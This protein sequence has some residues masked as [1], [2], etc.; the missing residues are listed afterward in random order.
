MVKKRKIKSMYLVQIVCE[1]CGEPMNCTYTL[2][3]YPPQYCYECANCGTTLRT[4]T[5]DG[6]IEYEFEEEENV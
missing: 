6:S 4:P 2:C 5:K 1:K 3:S